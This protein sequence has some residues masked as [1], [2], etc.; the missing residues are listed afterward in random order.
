MGFAR[1]PVRQ[2]RR[3]LECFHRM[4]IGKSLSILS[5]GSPGFVCRLNGILRESGLVLRWELS[6]QSV[7]TGIIESAFETLESV[8]F[9]MAVLNFDGQL[10]AV[11][12]KKLNPH[13]SL[14]LHL[15][16]GR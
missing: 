1:L 13:Y 2:V 5:S 3:L 11:T 10:S 4:R 12:L 9:G 7:A 6:R 15:H 16:R 8:V 14:Q